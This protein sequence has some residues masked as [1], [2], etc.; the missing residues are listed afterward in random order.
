MPIDM[1]AVTT[2]PKAPP[3]RRTNAPRKNAT[4]GAKAANTR[5]L[6]YQGLQGIAQLAQGACLFAKQYADAAAIGMHADPIAREIAA[7][8]DVQPAVARTVDLLIQ[9][10]P[11]AA[12]IQAV[13]PLAMQL[14]ANHRLIDA[15]GIPGGNIVPPEVLTAQMEA[16]M[17]Q[18]QADALR[19][20]QAAMREA[21][22]ARNDLEKLLAEHAREHTSV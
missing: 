15:S 9:A 7:L 3:Q 20:R 12:L 6:R 13:M 10:G 14:A 8:A 22:A 18:V 4:D 5:E 17:M 11:Y 2:P 16:R 1:S 19:E 21:E